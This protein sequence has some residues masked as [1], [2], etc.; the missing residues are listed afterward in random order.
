[1]GLLGPLIKLK[2]VEFEKKNILGKIVVRMIHVNNQN[3]NIIHFLKNE[4]I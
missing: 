3:S 2:Q 1:M 4:L